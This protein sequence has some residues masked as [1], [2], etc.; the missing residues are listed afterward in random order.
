M[1][2]ILIVLAAAIVTAVL[3]CSSGCAQIGPCVGY[4]RL[5]CEMYRYWIDADEDGEVDRYDSYMWTGKRMHLY[6][7]T[8]V[9][10]PACEHY[11]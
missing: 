7:R 4:E 1:K 9:N 3:M 2:I 11:R 6:Q 5:G 8:Y 10:P